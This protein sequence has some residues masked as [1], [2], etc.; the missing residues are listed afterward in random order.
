MS[1]HLNTAPLMPRFVF[2][3][4]SK[5]V[6]EINHPVHPRVETATQ[7]VLN[8]D[9]K[10]IKHTAASDDGVFDALVTT[11]SSIFRD[12]YPH[13]RFPRVECTETPAQNGMNELCLRFRAH[14]DVPAHMKHATIVL[15]ETYKPDS[16]FDNFLRTAS[17]IMLT[18]VQTSYALQGAKPCV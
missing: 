5:E 10:E 1:V 7:V 16:N 15:R 12:A 9:G 14:K 17:Q 8:R 4:A 11:L 13:N 2:L 18:G 6:T 3:N